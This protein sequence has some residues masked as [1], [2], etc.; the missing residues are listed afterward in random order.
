MKKEEKIQLWAGLFAVVSVVAVVCLFFEMA[1][2]N[3]EIRPFHNLKDTFFLYWKESVWFKVWVISSVLS[4]LICAPVGGTVTVIEFFIGLYMWAWF[5]NSIYAGHLL[6]TM[7]GTI[8]SLVVFSLIAL[9]VQAL[10]YGNK[11]EVSLT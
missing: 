1:N 7:W 8:I 4:S 6:L 3:L 9:V 11:K 5:H 10:I 2:V